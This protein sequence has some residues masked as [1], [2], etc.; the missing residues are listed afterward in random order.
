MHGARCYAAN[1]AFNAT[2][3]LQ[4]T[5]GRATGCRV[6]R[7]AT[8]ATRWS[9]NIRLQRCRQSYTTTTAR[10]AAK[11]R[12]ANSASDAIPEQDT[13]RAQ[14]LALYE[15]VIVKDGPTNLNE[16][17]KRHQ[18]READRDRQTYEKG[19]V[20]WKTHS[21]ALSEQIRRAR[22]AHHDPAPSEWMPPKPQM[23]LDYTGLVIEPQTS[24]TDPPMPIPWAQG[25]EVRKKSTAA[26]VLDLEIAAFADHMELTPAERKARL[27]VRNSANKAMDALDGHQPYAFGS[28]KTGLAMPFSDLDFGIFDKHYRQ[29]ALQPAMKY[30]YSTMMHNEDFI[31]VV[32]RPALRSIITAQH[33]ATGIE[34]QIVARESGSQDTRVKA[35]LDT[36]PYLHQLYSV[37]RTAFG[38]RGFVD[39]FIGGISSYGTFMMLAAALTRRGTP[40]NIHESPSSQL[41]HFLSFWA[42]FD[43]TKYGMSLSYPASTYDAGTDLVYDRPAKLFRKFTLDDKLLYEKSE[44]QQAALVHAAKR[45]MQNQRAGQYRIGRLK[46]EQPYLLCLQ[47][48]ANPI[49]DLGATC[50]A[51]KHILQTIKAL[52]AD[53]VRAME[54]HDRTPPENRPKGEMSFLLPLVGRS[55]EL[56]AERRQRL[57]DWQPSTSLRYDKVRAESKWRAERGNMNNAGVTRKVRF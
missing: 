22:R 30:L 10:G 8:N 9:D 39:P 14:R 19:S 42:N 17:R 47:D 33:K 13:R 6:G 48:P 40:Y 52:H 56:Y 26:Q 5:C 54:E 28:T 3:A 36:V 44:V 7:L 16:E 15:E 11:K 45:R 55:H 38:V 29:H 20:D 23:S 24:N 41:L 51:I 21:L 27:H 12:D 43:T 4:L 1:A 34:V 31:C 35:Y 37:V 57:R 18:T 50:H 25:Y 53:L 46:P 2:S 32:Y 49:N